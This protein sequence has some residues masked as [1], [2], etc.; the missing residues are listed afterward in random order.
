MQQKS[1]RKAALKLQKNILTKACDFFS[2]FFFLCRAGEL[3]T[4]GGKSFAKPRGASTCKHR[5]MASWMRAG[6]SASLVAEGGGAKGA[7]ILRYFFR[8]SNGDGS[9]PQK[10]LEPSS[11]LRFWGTPKAVKVWTFFRYRTPN[12][13]HISHFPTYE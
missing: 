13:G 10:V 4:S 1:V 6:G 9:S 11:P 8:C 2:V 7:L 12:D 3:L 5:H